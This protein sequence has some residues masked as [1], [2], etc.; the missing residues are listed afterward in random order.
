MKQ[1]LDE[2][3]LALGLDGG[4]YVGETDDDVEREVDLPSM[5]A[6]SQGR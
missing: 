2:Q 3:S 4:H 5:Q 6:N 1:I